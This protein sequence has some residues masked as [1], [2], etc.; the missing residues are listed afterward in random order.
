MLKGGVGGFDFPDLVLA[1][2]FHSHLVPLVSDIPNKINQVCQKYN[3]PKEKIKTV[4]FVKQK[5][6]PYW[7]KNARLFCFPSLYEGFGL[8]VLEAMNSGCPVVA[9]NNSSIP[10]VCSED[11]A[12]LINAEDANETAEAMHD[13]LADRELAREKIEAAQEETKR[14]SWDKFVEGFWEIVNSNQSQ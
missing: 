2:K 8:P 1:G 12:M 5:D 10:E 3:L 13:L 4:G 6:L 9:G 7:Y 14:F 11:S